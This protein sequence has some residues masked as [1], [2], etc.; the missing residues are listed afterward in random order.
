MSGV[1]GGM[2]LDHAKYSAWRLGLPL[3]LMP[4]VLSVDASY[5]RAV[6]V[7]EDGRVKYVGNAGLVLTAILI[8]YDLIQ[9]APKIL[10]TAGAGDILSC[11]TGLWDWRES[12]RL[13]GEEIDEAIV[14][15]TQSACLDRLYGGA[16]ELR[17]QSEAGLCL[18]SELFAEEVRLCE[19][20]GN[21]RAEE[22]SEHSLAYR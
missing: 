19:Q 15:Q 22:G 17:D 18:L 21:A 9:S 1:G 6:G 10:N 3:V 11:F 5:T 4:S 14:A 20:W 12:A 16:T 2:A 8:D 13:L 7:R